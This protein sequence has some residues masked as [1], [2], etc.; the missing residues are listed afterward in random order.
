VKI[1]EDTG[2]TI[3]F[4]VDDVSIERVE[5]IIRRC[6]GV[7]IEKTKKPRLVFLR[8]VDLIEYVIT[9]NFPM[10]YLQIIFKHQILSK[11][12]VVIMIV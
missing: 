8:L 9:R 2:H 1:L 10:N 5:F 7:S 11:K 6:I 4:V 3:I 12:S